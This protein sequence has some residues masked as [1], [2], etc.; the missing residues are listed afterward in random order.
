[1]STSL[2]ILSE[3]VL[4]LIISFID[5]L[6]VL[7]VLARVSKHFNRLTLPHLYANVS[8]VG[9]ASDTGTKHLRPLTFLML[10]KPQLAALVRALTL[11]SAYASEDIRRPIG[12]EPGWIGWPQHSGLDVALKTAIKAQLGRDTEAATGPLATHEAA[13][14]DENDEAAEDEAEK[15]FQLVRAGFNEAAILAL[16]LP[17]LVNLQSMDV[18]FVQE[19]D[20]LGEGFSVQSHFIMKMFERAA[21]R[22][23]LVQNRPIFGGLTD[24]I[25]SGTNDK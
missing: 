18:P 22:Q 24:V 8:F 1:M 5:H 9:A 23:K 16:L 25:I 2:E 3:D 19:Y 21:T 20:E 7:A 14:K 12:D 4:D 10:Q 6:P 11:R 17:N 13:T 15:C